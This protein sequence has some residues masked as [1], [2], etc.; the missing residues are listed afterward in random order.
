MNDKVMKYI[1]IVHIYNKPARPQGGQP[2]RIKYIMNDKYTKY[3][4]IVH[5][6]NKPARPQ[7][8]RPIHRKYEKYFLWIKAT[9][10]LLSQLSCNLSLLY[11]AF[12][13]LS[14]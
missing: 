11:R 13:R 4:C 5:V 7:R 3:I 9:S 12:K 10:S 2:F 14:S 6:Y 1:C 8:S